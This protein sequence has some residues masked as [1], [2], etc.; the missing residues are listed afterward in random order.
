MKF[1]YL[2]IPNLD[3][4][5]LVA[6]FEVSD[7][8]PFESADVTYFWER[9]AKSISISQG[10]VHLDK[11]LIVSVQ[12]SGLSLLGGYMTIIG[13]LGEVED[14]RSGVTLNVTELLSSNQLS[15]YALDRD[16]IKSDEDICDSAKKVEK[17]YGIG[18]YGRIHP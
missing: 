10:G 8:W 17:F 16:K 3:H 5:L 2:T 13:N 18:L 14:N 9:N 1:A 11:W 15:E 4:E 12:R 6:C 7:E